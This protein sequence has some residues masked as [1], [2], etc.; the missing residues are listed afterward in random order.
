[1]D[2]DQQMLVGILRF[3]VD[4]L[5]GHIRPHL[6]GSFLVWPGG[7]VRIDSCCKMTR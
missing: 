4:A 5:S 6:F 1:M 3:E 7:V 2:P